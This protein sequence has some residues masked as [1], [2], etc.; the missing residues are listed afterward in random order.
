[1]RRDV[2]RDAVRRQRLCLIHHMKRSGGHAVIHWLTKNFSRAVFVNNEIPLQPILDGRRSIPDGRMPYEDWVRK[3]ER[4]PDYAEVLSAAWT[5]LVS[6][7]D[8]ELRV[9]PFSHPAIETIVVIRRPQ[10]L[11]ASRI[12]KSSGT[13]LLA[14]DIDN[15]ELLGRAVRIWKEHAR[16]ALGLV[17]AGTS[18]Q[19]I[20]YDAWL[21]GAHYRA[22]LARNFEFGELSDP[23]GEP[24]TEGGGSSFGQA[25]FDQAALLRR[26][27]LLDE[28]QRNVLE[29][30]MSDPEMTHLDDRIEERIAKIS[31]PRTGGFPLQ[32][33]PSN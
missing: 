32:P 18:L 29:R 19:T 12:K 28:S 14:Y 11:F 10:N 7:E 30:I 24:T 21:T 8:H 2:R 1:M 23:S 31:E 16:A 27:E 13:R 9:R 6:L 4:N 33:P 20:F 15:P 25:H 26:P 5:V 22:T 17:D 3:K